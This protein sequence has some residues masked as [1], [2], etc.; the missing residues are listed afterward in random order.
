VIFSGVGKTPEEI[1]LAL[2]SGVLFISAES[3]AEVRTIGEIAARKAL[4]A[5]VVLRTNPDVDA[6][7]HPYISTGLR[8]HKFG[9]P[10]EQVPKI[11]TEASR[12]PRVRVVGLGCHIGSQI[13]EIG[14]FEA[15]A[16]GMVALA[17]AMGE[18]APLEFLD[19]GGGLGVDYTGEAPPS[20]E[21]YARTLIDASR[22]TRLKLVLEPGRVIVARAGI[23]LCR[24]IRKKSQG[25]KT[26]VI[27]DAAMNDLIRPSLYKAFHEIRPVRP[28]D[29]REV[30]DVVGPICE[31]TDFL[32]QG[33]EVST[34]ESG[35]LVAV[36]TAGAY[37]A[38]LSS[39]YNSRP[40]GAEVL[41]SGKTYST[42]RRRETF[43]DLI[44][45]E[46]S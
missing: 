45:L 29:G 5:R 13:T 31:S 12:M 21:A 42:I 33:R 1:A 32:A 40:R 44:R 9:I 30:V 37:G 8:N 20:V 39:N 10:I 4:D 26:F 27:V 28:R 24:V 14:P 16:R 35:D 46:R 36:M 6:R 23:L 18:H 17:R 22:G 15:A 34:L 25:E 41:V 3:D 7:T 2:E 38:V 43:D 19:F 11:L